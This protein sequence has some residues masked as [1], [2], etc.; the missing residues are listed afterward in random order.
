MKKNLR[1]YVGIL[2]LTFSPR[3][4]GSGQE[5][6]ATIVGGSLVV[7]KSSAQYKHSARLL[8]KIAF[9]SDSKVPAFWQNKK[10]SYRCSA[11]IIKND[12][13]LTAG[14]CV[15][16]MIKVPKSGSGPSDTWAPIEITTVDVYYELNPREELAVGEKVSRIFRH[17]EFHENWEEKVGNAWN[18]SESINDIAILQLQDS[19]PGRK[20]AV[21]LEVRSGEEKGREFTLTG[22]GKSLEGG[23]LEVPQLR[24]V[25]VPYKGHL[26]NGKDMYV[27]VGDPKT[28]A[29]LAKPS[30]ACFGD[31]GGGAFHMDNGNA[32]LTGV[33]VR[34]PS[35]EGGGC[36]S[37]L[38]VLTD[39]R[40]YMDWIKLIMQSA[41]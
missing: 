21:S 22:Y 15:P 24:Q 23:E 12:L 25:Q 35:D 26:A 20:A 29:E 7:D 5:L 1:I 4:Y 19:I 14:H 38:T 32:K 40:P 6:G 10:L 27:G 11:S 8:V 2:L 17:P 28:P 30:G 34:G 13:L 31:S 41:K 36:R 18:P 33:I 9:G 39:I 37:G 16:S 3:L